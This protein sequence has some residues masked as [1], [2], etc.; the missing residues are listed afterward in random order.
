MSARACR[1]SA[2]AS[3]SS[4][5]AASASFFTRTAACSFSSMPARASASSARTESSWERAVPSCCAARSPK[6]T[7]SRCRLRCLS[8]VATTAPCASDT[9]RAAA[10]TAA[11]PARARG[12]AGI[13]SMVDPSCPQM[14]ETDWASASPSVSSHSCQDRRASMSCWS[15]SLAFRTRTKV[16]SRASVSLSSCQYSRRTHSSPTA[17]S[18]HCALSEWRWSRSTPRRA[19]SVKGSRAPPGTGWPAASACS[20]SAAC[21]RS[22]SASVPHTVCCTVSQAPFM[23]RMRSSFTAATSCRSSATKERHPSGCPPTAFGL[24]RQPATRWERSL[25]RPPRNSSLSA[26][27]G[28]WSS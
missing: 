12:T 9:R 17:R 6:A 3:C 16:S 13:L 22:S 20:R 21:A 7:A 24:A 5:S 1:N 11:R 23:L 14:S 25:S 10:C 4:V 19:S 27:K 15:A 2:R 18:S 28:S 26:E 8:D